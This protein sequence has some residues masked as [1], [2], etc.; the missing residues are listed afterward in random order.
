MAETHEVTCDGCGA[1]LTYTGNSV[2]YRLVLDAEPKPTAPDVNAVTDMLIPRP[3]AR[4]HHFCALRCLDNWR[5]GR[6]ADH[7]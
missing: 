7:E 5:F 6:A 2:D 1:D 3:I 4:K